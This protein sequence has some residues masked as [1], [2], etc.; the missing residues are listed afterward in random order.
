MSMDRTTPSAESTPIQAADLAGNALHWAVA[1]AAGR[2][3][4]IY[5][6][7]D[8]EE[9]ASEGRPG[10]YISGPDK[11]GPFT[12][13]ENW[14]QG[15]PIIERENISVMKCWNSGRPSPNPYDAA[16][17]QIPF[18]GEE[19]NYGRW[20][21]GPTLLVAAMRS[22]VA[23]KLGDVVAVPNEVIASDKAIPQHRRAPR[24]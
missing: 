20:Y 6:F 4:P 10:F 24:P 3:D 1:R 8:A 11:T 21:Y 12:P 18:L 16:K 13:A 2:E 23:A 14:T 9:A 7:M 19:P 5:R 22:Y 17:A 15:G